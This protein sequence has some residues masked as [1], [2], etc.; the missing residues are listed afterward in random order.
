MKTQRL[1]PVPLGAR[2]GLLGEAGTLDQLDLAATLGNEWASRIVAKEN[3]K[4][5]AS[6]L[7]SDQRLPFG[8]ATELDDDDV[9]VHGLVRDDMV[10]GQD[11][12]WE[13]F[14]E[15]VLDALPL[16]SNEV[17]FVARALA[18]G[19]DGVILR[20]YTPLA[21]IGAATGTPD[22][23]DGARILAIVDENDPNAVLDVVAILPGPKVLRRHDGTWQEDDEFVR[24]LRSV[25]PPPV[26]ELDETQVASVLPQV[27]EQTKGSPFSKDDEKKPVTAA[28]A[29]GARADE[30]AIEFALLAA[31]V[32]KALSQATPGGRA[33]AQLKQYWA[34]GRG[35]A[36]IRW[37]TPGAWRRCHRQLTK[38]V[39]PVIAKGL[40]TNIAKLRGGHG[41]ATH[42]GD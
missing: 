7:G 8:I 19:F 1:Y 13:S 14:N 40:C 5:L 41:V 29:F 33:P 32:G 31:P 39:G 3:A 12:T 23:P 22:I 38:Y 34:Y 15:P 26:V 9:I 24:V 30:M 36:K 10:L 35:A 17:A 18:D 16:D 25:K 20:G 21:I 37:G 6:V 11:G 27:D 42:V 2:T 4:L 28:A